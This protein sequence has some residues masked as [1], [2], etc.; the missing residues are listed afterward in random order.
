MGVTG[1][2]RAG[3]GERTGAPS[4][5][6]VLYKGQQRPLI[7]TLESGTQNQLDRDWAGLH[8]G[9]AEALGRGRGLCARRARAP[10]GRSPQTGCPPSSPSASSSS[11]SWPR[12]RLRKPLCPGTLG[13]RSRPAPMPPATRSIFLRAVLRPTALPAAGDPVPAPTHAVPLLVSFAP[14]GHGWARGAVGASRRPVGKQP[15]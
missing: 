7:E 6:P 2:D 3:P 12:R 9:D 10:A 14:G 15:G 8:L 4:V 5:R 13:Q 1:P 11:P